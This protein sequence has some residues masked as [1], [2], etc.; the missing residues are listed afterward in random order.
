MVHIVDQEGSQFDAPIDVLWKYLQSPT[1]HGGAHRSTR[2]QSMKPINET[3]FILSQEQNM[4][5]QW[6]KTANRITIFPPLGMAI[7]VLEG[8]MAGSRMFNVYT[9]RGK[10]TEIA[11]YSDMQSAVVPAPQLEPAVRMFWE[12]AF[13]EDTAGIREFTKRK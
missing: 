5:G 2:N 12:S 8:P 13:N 6:V 1:D 3:S 7:E 10:K 9:P 4:N 11:V